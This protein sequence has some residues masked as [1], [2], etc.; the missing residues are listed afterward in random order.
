MYIITIII[1][2]IFIIIIIIIY[3]HLFFFIIQMAPYPEGA[4][5]SAVNFLGFNDPMMSPTGKRLQFASWK[6]PPFSS[7]DLWST[8]IRI[9]IIY[10][11]Y[12]RPGKPTK[13]DGKIHH[14][15]VG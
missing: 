10:V 13:N 11:S 14:F 15:L 7:W 5:V 6:D 12:T 9:N 8:R 1:F 2:I 3:I 4:T